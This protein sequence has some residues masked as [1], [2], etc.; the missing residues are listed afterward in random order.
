MRF[1][2]TVVDSLT[3]SAQAAQFSGDRCLRA[4]SECA[5]LEA[6][7]MISRDGRRAVP[8][9]LLGLTITTGGGPASFHLHLDL[10]LPC[11]V[12]VVAQRHAYGQ[13]QLTWCKPLPAPRTIACTLNSMDGRS[14]QEHGVN[15]ATASPMSQPSSESFT[16]TSLLRSTPLSAHLLEMSGSS[17]DERSLVMVF[18]PVHARSHG[19]IPVV[20]AGLQALPSDEGAPYRVTAGPYPGGLAAHRIQPDL[21]Q[22]FLSASRAALFAKPAHLPSVYYQGATSVL[23]AYTRTHIARFC[24]VGI[25]T[26]PAGIVDIAGVTTPALSKRTVRWSTFV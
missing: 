7:A 8:A 10:H 2:K 21:V 6:R 24:A 12:R 1:D 5:V 17:R 26:K 23:D 25:G 13:T 4:A 3:L 19:A 15:M 16:N 22:S 20:V 9:L 14:N 18:R 11:V